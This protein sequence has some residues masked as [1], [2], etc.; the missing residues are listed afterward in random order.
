ML[1]LEQWEPSL[2]DNSRVPRLRGHVEHNPAIDVIIAGC[3]TNIKLSCEALE[4]VN[5]GRCGACAYITSTILGIRESDATDTQE[6]QNWV[7]LRMN[8]YAVRWHPAMTTITDV[9]RVRID[10]GRIDAIRMLSD[11]NGL[12]KQSP[13]LATARMPSRQMHWQN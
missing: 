9:V 5:R 3:P 8:E 13:H 11:R 6:D 7:R 10:T 12:G 4:P 2:A 1:L